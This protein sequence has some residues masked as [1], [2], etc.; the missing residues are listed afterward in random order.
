MSDE[1]KSY[2]I[3]DGYSVTKME[4]RR[5]FD[6]DER[7]EIELEFGFGG[8][9]RIS[10]GKDKAWIQLTCKIFEEEFFKKEAPFYLEIGLEGRF[11]LSV[12]EEFSDIES[13]QL[14]G[15]AILL[16]HLRAIVT[17]FTSQTGMPPVILPPINVYRAFE[18]TNQNNLE[19]A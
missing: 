3:F 11:E 8:S 5:N 9:A 14:N 16:P 10:D 17:S 12:N 7:K 2:L 19:D 1:L 18:M 13:F 15:L 6:F 4:F